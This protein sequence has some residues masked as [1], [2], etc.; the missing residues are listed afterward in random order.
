MF[1]DAGIVLRA[2]EEGD[3]ERIRSLRND[4]TTWV[5][6]TDISPI[7]ADDQRQWFLTVNRRNDRGYF[8]VADDDH[9]FIG[10]VRM[11]EID[12][13]NRSIR[14]GADV[15]PELRGRG[16]GS[17]VY[18]ALLRY[19]FDYL[20]MHRVWLAV[21]ATNNVATRLYEKHGFTVEGRYRDAIFRDGQYVDYIL[22]SIL[23][24]EYK[25]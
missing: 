21:L 6:L 12:R 23:E 5:H 17:K 8:V 18:Q 3:L 2:V 22:M 20:N 10:I 13:A 9:A 14:V 4:P 1:R 15:V 25:R 16:F 11:D 19:C 7:G 24:G